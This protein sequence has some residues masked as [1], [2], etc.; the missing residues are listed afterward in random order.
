MVTVCI[1]TLIEKLNPQDDHPEYVRRRAQILIRRAELR[2][3]QA[4]LTKRDADLDALNALASNSGDEYLRL[5]TRVLRAR[6]MNLDARY[7]QAIAAAEEGIILADQMQDMAAHCY[8]LTQIGFA[9]YFLG[10]PRQALHALDE[11]LRM[12]PKTDIETRRHILHVL[13][14]VH[15]HLGNYACALAHQQESLAIHQTIGDYDGLAW[16]GLD[17]A[18]TR[19]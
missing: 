2:S 19:W 12:T 16:A 6:F 7:E 10:K 3:L 5:Q 9:C 1:Q 11:A 17:M 13:G 14:Y 8:L 18:A 4:R 15:F